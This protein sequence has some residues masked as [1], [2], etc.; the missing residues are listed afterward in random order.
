M[1]THRIVVN[2]EMFTKIKYFLYNTLYFDRKLIW[3]ALGTYN[4]SQGL[5]TGQKVAYNVSMW[6]IGGGALSIVDCQIIV[7]K[8]WPWTIVGNMFGECHTLWMLKTSF[9]DFEK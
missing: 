4:N 7:W 5:T 9:V 3:P 2:W 1:L 6:Q 8:A